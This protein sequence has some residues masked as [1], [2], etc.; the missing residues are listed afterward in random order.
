M[1][2]HKRLPDLTPFDV[3]IGDTGIVF[4]NPFDCDVPFAVVEEFCVE[5]TV[6]HDEVADDTPNDGECTREDIDVFPGGKGPG[7][8]GHRVTQ[9]G[10]PHV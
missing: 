2:V 9:K 4:T 10:E 1:R 6:G 3:M 5:G 8:Y 7:D